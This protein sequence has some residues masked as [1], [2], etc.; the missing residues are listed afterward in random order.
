M[1]RTRN[2]RRVVLDHL[3]EVRK[4][5]QGYRSIWRTR[6]TVYVDQADR[7]PGDPCLRPRQPEEYPENQAQAWA[8][9]FGA[10]EEVITHAVE[11]R[12]LARR[13]YHATLAAQRTELK[14]EDGNA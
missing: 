5:V 12:E 10:M 3:N 9:L 7:K 14:T 8:R 13:Q 2:P 1:T 11:V 6:S 4:L